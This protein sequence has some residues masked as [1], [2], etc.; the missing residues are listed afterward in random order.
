MAL[1]DSTLKLNLNLTTA[2]QGSPMVAFLLVPPNVG[3]VTVNIIPA[4]ASAPVP[5]MREGGGGDDPVLLLT[6]PMPTPGIDSVPKAVDKPVSLQGRGVLPP[7]RAPKRVLNS[8][9][10]PR[11]KGSPGSRLPL[12]LPP[13]CAPKQQSTPANAE[14]GPS[15]LVVS[16][17]P[18][19]VAGTDLLFS[20]GTGDE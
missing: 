1:P 10:S 2:A 13:R 15:R 5:G 12:K 18:R 16:G 17:S 8:P 19:V 14:A 6:G 4:P 7:Q 20:D 3:R 11:V 9:R